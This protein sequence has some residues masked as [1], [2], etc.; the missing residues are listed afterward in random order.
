[1]PNHKIMIVEDEEIVAADI[2]TSIEKM[3]YA[4]CAMASSGLE[5]IQKAGLTQPDLALMDIVLKGSMDGIE[6]A[7]QIKKLYKIPVVYLTAFGDDGILQRAKI[8]APYGY[9]IKPFRDR[10][11]QI[12]IEISIYRKQAEMALQEAHDLLEQRVEERTKQLNESLSQAEELTV[13]A[14]AASRAKSLFIGNMSHEL[15]TPLSGVLGMTEALLNTPLADK[16]RDYAETIRKSGKALL[17]VVGNILDFSKISAGNMALESSP[18]QVEA[19]IANVVNLF[20]PAAAEEKIGLH[21]T[22]DPALPA[23]RGDV[24]RLTQVVSNLVGNAVKFTKAG[25]IQVAVKI[26]RRTEA[27]VELAIGV[28]DTGIGMTEEEISRIFTGFTQGDTSRARRFGGTGLGLTI[29]RNLVE[30]MGGKLQ[31]ESV[32]GKGSLFTVLVTFPIAQGFARSDWKSDPINPVAPVTPPKPERPP[33][34][35]AELHALLEQL[36]EPLDNGEPRPCKDIL[37]TLL[38]KSWPE[39][40]ETLLAELNR[41]VNRYRLQEALDLLNKDAAER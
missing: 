29:S 21:V 38:T 24:H 11:L 26:L 25:E 19:V 27:E 28:Q 34:D 35:M 3:G 10:D 20:G 16:Q 12:A 39:E 5:A 15:R 6:A 9:I 1:M 30:L 22:M 36:K 13:R 40:Q 17:A 8:S 37:A 14:E 23:V 7:A 41:L 18:F 32:F 31:V 4:V 2:Q 33:G